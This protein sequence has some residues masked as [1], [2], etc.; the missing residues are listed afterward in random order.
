MTIT[1]EVTQEAKES[2]AT[3]AEARGLSLDAF[4]HTIVTAQAA[5]VAPVTPP[6]APAGEGEDPERAI[7]ELFDLVAIA[8]E[9]GEGAAARR[10]WYQ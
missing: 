8:P 1:L 10:N 9:A 6:S 3:Q 7:D 4:L 5:T 2:L